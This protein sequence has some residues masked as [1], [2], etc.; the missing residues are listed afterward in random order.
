M[1]VIGESLWARRMR[2]FA[3]VGCLA[4]GASLA[5]A[6]PAVAND[7]QTAQLS[8]PPAASAP[9][10]S[11][12]VE[13]SLSLDESI[14]CLV[15][16]LAGTG[17]ALLAGGQNLVNV[18]AGG[19]VAPA[20]PLVLYTGLVG[21]VFA[22]FCAVGQALTPLYVYYYNYYYDYYMGTPVSP[23]GGAPPSIDPQVPLIRTSN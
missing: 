18:V 16:G 3:C 8:P 11:L 23:A 20:N 9:T 2:A 13:D 7:S 22:S 21:V 4:V 6:M 10:P 5:A 14:G 12:T 19:L 1:K 15:G 17:A